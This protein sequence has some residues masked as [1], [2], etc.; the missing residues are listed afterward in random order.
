MRGTNS[1]EPGR[2]LPDLSPEALAV[3]TP[4]LVRSPSLR[5]QGVGDFSVQVPSHMHRLYLQSV[6]NGRW[7]LGVA[8]QTENQA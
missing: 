6:W 3:F 2:S 4:A 8:W 1:G 7:E 5:A